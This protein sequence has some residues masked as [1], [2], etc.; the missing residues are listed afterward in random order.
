MSGWMPGM[1]RY[2][3]IRELEFGR[4]A[5]DNIKKRPYYFQ[6]LTG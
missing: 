3:E 6:V 1:L 5:R 4:N 2:L